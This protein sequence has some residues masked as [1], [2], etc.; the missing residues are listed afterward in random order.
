MRTFRPSRRWRSRWRAGALHTPTRR[1]HKQPGICG[2]EPRRSLEET[3]A[4][5]G[6][7]VKSGSEGS[8]KK[9]RRSP[10]LADERLKA[11]RHKVERLKR[12]GREKDSR[13]AELERRCNE[14]RDPG[15]TVAAGASRNY[16]EQA[17]SR[18]PTEKEHEVPPMARGP[19]RAEGA[20]ETQ[21]P[22]PVTASLGWLPTTKKE[23]EAYLKRTVLGQL[24]NFM[25]TWMK[26]DWEPRALRM[27]RLERATPLEPL[28]PSTEWGAASD[29]GTAQDSVSA[30]PVW[31]RG[32]G[33]GWEAP[34]P[35][36][37]ATK[38]EEKKEVEGG[39]TN[40]LA[41]EGDKETAP[42]HGGGPMVQG[43]GT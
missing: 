19:C 39:C 25:D 27:L 20:P 2:A 1:D 41:G 34:T 43:A 9:G 18:F 10:I 22:S 15:S 13:I 7:S 21:A 42:N 23:F 29:P 40:L 17:L 33:I 4:P 14:R 28:A 31:L 36:T 38:G 5:D 6:V 32:G 26:E 35:T 8:V 12:E 30:T 11:L 37:E 24:S 16:F 3:I